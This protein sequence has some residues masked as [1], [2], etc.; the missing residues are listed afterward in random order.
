M[1]MQN[2]KLKIAADVP[3]PVPFATE[4]PQPSSTSQ[5]KATLRKRSSSTGPLLPKTKQLAIFCNRSRDDQDRP[6]SNCSSRR[7]SAASVLSL[8]RFDK[9]NQHLLV[10]S[11]KSQH[12]IDR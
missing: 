8:H 9:P 6:P 2:P 7:L 4:N 12:N 10:T 3:S 1:N 5:K 11:S